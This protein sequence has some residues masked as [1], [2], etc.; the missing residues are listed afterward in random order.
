M[1]VWL[2]VV[3][4]LKKD[5]KYVD[6]SLIPKPVI[7]LFQRLKQRK[8]PVS[9]LPATEIDWSR[10]DPKLSS[11]LMQFQREGVEYVN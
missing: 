8:G 11:T 10:I 1:F 4:V 6:L 7:G 2:C 9:N 5:C 3:D